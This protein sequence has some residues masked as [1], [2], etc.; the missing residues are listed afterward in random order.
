MEKGLGTFNRQI[1]K[2]D[3]ARGSPPS[4]TRM[5]YAYASKNSVTK[6][7][8]HDRRRREVNTSFCEI[9][10]FTE[11]KEVF[12]SPVTTAQIPTLRSRIKKQPIRQP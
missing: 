1:R 9:K 6:P 5:Q 10:G 11:Q 4:H 8:R 2:K 7:R 12:T 3:L